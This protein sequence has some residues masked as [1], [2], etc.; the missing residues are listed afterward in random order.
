MPASEPN[1]TTLITTDELKTVRYGISKDFNPLRLDPY[2]IAGSERL[3]VWVGDAV[4]DDALTEADISA[5]TAAAQARIK[6]RR[7]I[8]KAAEGDLAMSYLTL[9]LDT[10]VTP[11]GQVAE[12][13]AEGQ[14]VHRYFN[15]DQVAKTARAWL[16][17]AYLLATP[18]LL[19]ADIPASA[20]ELQEIELG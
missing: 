3:R 6:A 5:L 11:N 13:Q 16:E 8:L 7:E 17:Q 15:P 19:T 1:K 12:A 2:V 20:V 10:F 4:Y 14:T 9:N 18:Y